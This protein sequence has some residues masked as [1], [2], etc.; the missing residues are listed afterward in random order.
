LSEC[1]IMIDVYFCYDVR[2]IVC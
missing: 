2:M 1:Y